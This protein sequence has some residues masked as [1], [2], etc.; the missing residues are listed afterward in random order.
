ML[1]R[2]RNLYRPGTNGIGV[3]AL[4][5]ALARHMRLALHELTQAWGEVHRS[6][7]SGSTHIAIG[8]LPLMPKRWVASAIARLRAVHPE[9]RVE[10]REEGYSALLHDLRWGAVDLIL[11]ALPPEDGEADVAREPLL[12]D[13]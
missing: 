6:R 9:A 8:T 11:G 2:S 3:N 10:L 4:G 7:G 1:F 12:V 5:E 13:P